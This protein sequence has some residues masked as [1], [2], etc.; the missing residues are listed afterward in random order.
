MTTIVVA[1]RR[2]IVAWRKAPAGADG[3]LSARIRV[4]PPRGV[5]HVKVHAVMS[6][7][8]RSVTDR[9]RLRRR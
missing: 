4:R 6:G 3:R 1:G 2:G 9:V 8:G 5:R 7:G